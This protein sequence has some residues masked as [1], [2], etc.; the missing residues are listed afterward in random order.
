[1]VV[2]WFK[3]RCVHIFGAIKLLLHLPRLFFFFWR[4]GGNPAFLHSEFLKELCRNLLTIFISPFHL[5]LL[6]DYF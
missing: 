3:Y 5:S 6:V 2:N 4:G 1:M